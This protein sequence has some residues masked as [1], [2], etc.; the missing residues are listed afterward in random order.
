M[1][2]RKM[3]AEEIMSPTCIS[4]KSVDTV[5]N[6]FAALNTPHHGFPILNYNN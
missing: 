6:I 3:R 1:V 4:L 2:N 5:K